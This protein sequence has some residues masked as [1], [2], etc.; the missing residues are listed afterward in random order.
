MIGAD[1]L[2]LFEPVAGRLGQDLSLIRYAGEN[3]VEGAEAVGGYDDTVAVRQIVVF[4]HLATVVIRQL[5]NDGFIENAHGLSNSSLYK[6][7]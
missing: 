5:G 3:T 1:V 4:P 6:G 2:C 7:T